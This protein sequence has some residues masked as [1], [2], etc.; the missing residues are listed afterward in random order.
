MPVEDG[1]AQQ[2]P[3]NFRQEQ[4]RDGSQL[5]SGCGMARNVDSQRAQLLDQAPNFRAAGRNLFRN[6]GAAHHHHRVLHQQA[7]D[8]PQANVGGLR[9]VGSSRSLARRDSPHAI[10]AGLSDEGIMR[11]SRPNNNVPRCR[12]SLYAA[13]TRRLISAAWVE[14]V[15]RPTEIKST[16]ASANARTFSRR[17]PPEHSTGI[18]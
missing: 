8:V 13:T 2:R 14:C 9:F 3:Q 12:R 5:V 17:I 18:R 10:C 6:L 7:H 11:E 16:P 1:S 15:S 4:I